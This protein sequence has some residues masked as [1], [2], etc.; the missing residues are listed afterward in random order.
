MIGRRRQT[1]CC[2]LP[3]VP[4]N[5]LQPMEA[6]RTFYRTLCARASVCVC[7][8][9]FVCLPGLMIHTYILT[10]ILSYIHTYMHTYIHTYAYIYIYP[11]HRFCDTVLGGHL[12]F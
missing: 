7:V 5:A 3:A 6:R 11:N 12:S 9:V 1:L 8:C 4:E 10:Y 2:G